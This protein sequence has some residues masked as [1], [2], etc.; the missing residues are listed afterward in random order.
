[1]AV[2]M[3]VDALV[4]WPAGL[5]ARIGHPVTW[6]GALINVLDGR[7]NRNA[8]APA[9]RRA[10]GIAAVLLVVGL[11]A[12]AGFGRQAGFSSGAG[13]VVVVGLMAWPLF[14]PRLPP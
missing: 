10:A 3:A 7:C 6:L 9:L 14:A 4:G 2:A 13:P 12:G 1:M 11:A 5:F 8:D